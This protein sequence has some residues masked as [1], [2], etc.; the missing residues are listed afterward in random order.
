MKHGIGVLI[1]FWLGAVYEVL[2]GRGKLL[3]DCLFAEPK[4]VDHEQTPRVGHEIAAIQVRTDVGIGA[5]GNA[6]PQVDLCDIVD[7]YR[8][9]DF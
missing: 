7:L 6:K 3:S 2:I 5:W 1:A 9:S 8:I 4:E